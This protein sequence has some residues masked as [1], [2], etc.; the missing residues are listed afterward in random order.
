MGSRESL[1]S[2]SPQPLYP[3]ANPSG[4]HSHAAPLSSIQAHDTNKDVHEIPLLLVAKVAFHPSPRKEKKN[5]H[6]WDHCGI[7]YH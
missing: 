1:L 6:V 5:F 3:P 7:N 2:Q 4:T